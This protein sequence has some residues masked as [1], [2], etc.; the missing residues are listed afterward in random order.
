MP[1]KWLTSPE[2]FTQEQ[3]TSRCEED[4]KILGPYRMRSCQDHITCPT[5]CRQNRYG[6]ATLLSPIGD[7]C[8]SNNSEEREEEGRCS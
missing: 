7:V 2:Q 8:R 1:T 4:S 5:Y 6:D 3:L